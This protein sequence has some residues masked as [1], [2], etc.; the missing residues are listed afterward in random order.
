MDVNYEVIR[1]TQSKLLSLLI[2]L[3]FS[4]LFVDI[5]SLRYF[6]KLRKTIYIIL[7]IKLN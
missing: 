3:L 7:V 6:W 4:A 2:I 5:T 1:R